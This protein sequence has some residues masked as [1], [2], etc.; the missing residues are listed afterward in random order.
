MR[1]IL[2]LTL[3]LI[4]LA[5]VL[6][7]TG[8]VAA[9]REHR[10]NSEQLLQGLDILNQESP[11]FR[12]MDSALIALNEAENNFRLYTASYERKHLTIFGNQ[13]AQVSSLLDSLS[14][15][16]PGHPPSQQFNELIRKKEEMSDKLGQLKK[17][18]DSLLTRS[19]KDEM[20]DK[21][22]NSI[23][24][25]N[26]SKVKKDE[27][28]MDTTNN[29]EEPKKEKKG[30][31]KRLGN[32]ISNK[33]DT[34]KAQQT[35]MVRTKD[36]KVMDK[37]TYDAQR[38]RNIIT[39]VNVYYKDILRKQLQGRSQI[40][41]NEALLA[42]T[43]IVLLEDVKE[44]ILKLREQ[45]TKEEAQIK[46]QASADVKASKEKMDILAIYGLAGLLF[47]MALGALIC[48]MLYIEHKKLKEAE[49]SA[50]EVA[51]TRSDFLNNMSHEIRT[52]L[53]SIV[54]FS[55][56]LAHTPLNQDQQ[57]LLKAVSISSD[58]LM[59]VVNDV[60]DFSKLESNYISIQKQPF[61]LYSAFEEVIST[62]RIQ[63][64]KKQLA[65]KFDFHGN[66]QCHVLG[67]KFRL[68]QILVNLISN[69]IK[70]TDAGEVS[71][72]VTLKE[73]PEEKVLLSFTVADSGPGISADALPHIF[74]RFYQVKSPRISEIK[75]TGLGLAITRRLLVMHGGDIQVDSEPGKGSRFTGHITYEVTQATSMA[76]DKPKVIET[77]IGEGMADKYVLI[78]DDQEMNLLLL[79]MILTRW[80]CRFD[81]AVN[82]EIAWNLFQQHH[83]DIVLLDL[84]MPEMSGMEVIQRIRKDNDPQKSQVPVLVLTADIS[85]QDI[86]D[87]RKAGF[88][89]W[90][91]KPTREK[92]IYE[93]MMKYVG[94]AKA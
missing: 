77:R 89:D 53:N 26:V 85:Q 45:T 92:D 40:N 21:L 73:Q 8:I 16:E 91:L 67:D 62:M 30:F 15:S 61:Q 41:T 90:L 2:T 36:G 18:T 50:L 6:I 71:V 57:E 39:D 20:I 31:F 79:K 32:A 11:R 93:T 66:Q 72:E 7:A 33:K 28:V 64:T 60:L 47:C 3:I 14:V 44:L 49:R 86:I 42:S 78:A 10:S 63:A 22:V 68:K 70:Y 17:A 12:L 58:M 59:E 24:V 56:E 46:L 5:F 19:L 83:Y 27:V 23:P 37:Q 34:I 88:N 43:N 1:K 94:K 82:G 69:A 87:F 84:Q 29:I 51:Q 35:I 74:D 4:C 13:L 80:Q 9:Y 38:L 25:Y 48:S 54:G 75:G 52:P 81:M 65:L 55:E 76:A